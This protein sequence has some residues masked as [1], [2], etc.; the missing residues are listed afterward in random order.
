MED[1]SLPCITVSI[2]SERFLEQNRFFRVENMRISHQNLCDFRAK[3]RCVNNPKRHYGPSLLSQEPMLSCYPSW[4]KDTWQW[5]FKSL[6]VHQ[7]FEPLRDMDW[8]HPVIPY[9]WISITGIRR[10]LARTSPPPSLCSNWSPLTTTTLAMSLHYTLKW[11]KQ[12]I[13][14]KIKYLLSHLLINSIA[15]S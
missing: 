14:N 1:S 12:Y 7:R 4:W 5:I 9:W 6:I 8:S 2:N 3:I 10:I 11:H 15:A 13:E